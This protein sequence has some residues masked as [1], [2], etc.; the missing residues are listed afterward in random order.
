MATKREI[1]IANAIKQ[2]VIDAWDSTDSKTW[3]SVA[4]RAAMEAVDVVAVINEL[5][6]GGVI[7]S[8]DKTCYQCISHYK[9]YSLYESLCPECTKKIIPKF[10]SASMDVEW[11]P[12]ETAPKD[13]TLIRVLTNDLVTSV[14]VAQWSIVECK[15]VF[16]CAPI[17][18]GEYT[19]LS[20]WKPL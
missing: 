7:E 15:F 14:T 13:G 6:S 10:E 12:M 11:R 16:P 1:G 9:A 19:T 5:D 3:D 4:D 17:L 2:A 8:F 18:D 20:G